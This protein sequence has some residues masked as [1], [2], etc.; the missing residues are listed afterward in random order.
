[1]KRYIPFISLITLLLIA[2]CDLALSTSS[3]DSLL[4]LS[5]SVLPSTLEQTSSSDPSIASTSI[6]EGSSELPSS[7]QPTLVPVI[8]SLTINRDLWTSLSVYPSEE[9][10]VIFDQ[11]EFRFRAAGNYTSGVIQGKRNEFYLFNRTSLIHLVDIRLVLSQGHTAHYLYVGEQEK[12]LDNEIIAT[13]NSANTDFLY[14]IDT[15]TTYPYFNIVNGDSAIYIQSI[16]IRYQ[17]GTTTTA[18]SSQTSSTSSSTLPSTSSSSSSTTTSVPSSSSQSS[19]LTVSSNAPNYYSALSPS[20]TGQALKEALDILISSNVSVNYDWS[21]FT[22]VD[23]SLT[24]SSAVITIYP[25]QNY[26]KANQVGSSQSPGYWNREHTY[27]QSKIGG[28]A[29]SDTHHLFADDHYTNSQRGNKKFG[30]VANT[31]ANR[32]KDS[33]NRLTNNYQTSTYFEPNDEAKGEVARATLYLNTLYGY[34]IDGNFQSTELAILWALQYPVNDWAMTRN[35]R[36]Y[37]A[38]GNRNPYIDHPQWI[39]SVY[40]QTSPSTIQACSA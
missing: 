4:S 27:P 14:T 36:I 11:F 17:D 33:L 12:P 21:R 38:Q 29:L 6:L 26:P 32:V 37:T 23:Q 10:S 24:D 15:H 19:T 22:F 35:N 7:E 2:S 1:M 13:A 30:D 9:T 28:N 40:G 31:E 3:E 8:K 25:K 20:L 18:P 5:S 16:T 39:C 34:S